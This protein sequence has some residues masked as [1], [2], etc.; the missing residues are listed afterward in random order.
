MKTLEHCQV[1]NPLRPYGSRAFGRTVTVI[2]RSEVVGRPLAALLANDGARV[3]SVDLDGVQEFNR[4]KPATGDSSSSGEGA[5]ATNK[6]SFHPY[7]T[8]KKTD[9]SLE[10][11]LKISDVVIGGVRFSLNCATLREADDMFSIV[12]SVEGIQSTNST[13]QGR[14]RSHQLFRIKE[15]RI[16][17]QRKSSLSSILSLRL[18]A[19]SLRSFF[20][21]C[22]NF[23]LT[24]QFSL[25]PFDLGIDLLSRYRKSNHRFTST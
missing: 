14:S 17:Y 21:H 8:V 3:F 15:F 6:P 5:S 20:V 11:C 9:A 16:R 22:K 13:P 24:V 18:F 25:Y 2:N 12:G 7:H 23:S 10:E 19:F 4:R 1:Y